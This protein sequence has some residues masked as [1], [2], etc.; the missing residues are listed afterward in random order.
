MNEYLSIDGVVEMTT[1]S[2][3]TIYRLI[4]KSGFPPAREIAGV[5]RSLWIRSEITEWMESNL[6]R[7]VA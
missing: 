2:V 5:A 7:K 4:S 3:A 1:F 6:K